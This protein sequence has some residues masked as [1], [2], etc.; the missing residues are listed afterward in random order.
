MKWG[1]PKG[2]AGERVNQDLQS[3][4]TIDPAVTSVYLNHLRLV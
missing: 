3:G 2:H 4:V 1:E